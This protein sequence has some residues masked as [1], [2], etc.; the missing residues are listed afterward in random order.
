MLTGKV[1][2]TIFSPERHGPYTY[3]LFVV[4][5]L[6]ALRTGIVGAAAAAWTTPIVLVL[7]GEG[8]GP[9]GLLGLESGLH[10]VQFFAAVLAAV[11]L[12][13]GATADALRRTHLD[14]AQ[15]LREAVDVRRRFE[16]IATSIDEGV[17]TYRRLPSQWVLDYASPAWGEIFGLEITPT[18]GDVLEEYIHPD[19]IATA[20]AGWDRVDAGEWVEQEYRVT[21]PQGQLRWVNE[22]LRLRVDESGEWI[23]GIVSDVTVRRSEEQRREKIAARLRVMSRT[24]GLTGLANRRHL[25]AEL[26]RCLG[27]CREGGPGLGLLLLDLDRFKVVND[28][29]GHEA[30]DAVLRQTAERIAEAT[31]D[32][33]AVAGALGWR[34]VLRAGPG[35]RRRGRTAHRRR[36]ASRARSRHGRCGST[37]APS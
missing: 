27:A 16:R 26:E 23:D 10:Q 18:A 7:T 20:R 8:G 6:I 22:R 9:Y 34:G 30:G 35:P 11:L 21:T 33:A 37:T 36:D 13:A 17:F 24:D 14:A 32:A 19:D 3:L 12:L 1:A 15:R 29:F 31:S 28:S 5:V 25:S 2:Y 4:P